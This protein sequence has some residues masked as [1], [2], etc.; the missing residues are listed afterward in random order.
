LFEYLSFNN[1]IA[2]NVLIFFYYIFV[3]LIPIFL[4]KSRGYLLKK[5]SFVYDNLEFKNKIY[6]FILFLGIFVCMELCLRLFF[7]MLVGYFDMH[8]YLYEISQ[9]L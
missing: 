8:D 6:I 7:E 4:W 1:F 2:Q 5:F 3:F 9:K